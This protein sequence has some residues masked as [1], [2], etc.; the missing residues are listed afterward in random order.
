VVEGAEDDGESIGRKAAGGFVWALLGFLLMQVGGFGTYTVATKIL[1]DSGIGVV[2][3]ALVLVFWIDI[4]LDLG[5]V[6][7]LIYEQERGQTERVQVAFTVNLSVAITVGLLI[8]FGAGLIDDLFKV[9]DER[10]FRVVALLVLVKGFGQVPNAMLERELNFKRK[11][12][13]DIVRSVGR[14]AI[15]ITLLQL[16]VGPIAM[17][18]GVTSAEIAAVSVTWWL[19]R[20]KFILRFDRVIATEMLKF[21]S[22]MFF[23]RLVGM[24]W[25]N[26]DNLI[27]TRYFGAR[28]K[29]F[30]N[31]FTA[32]RLPELI[33]GSVY[34]LFSNVA[35]PAYS[36]A[37]KVG[38]EVLREASLK[39]LRILC[40]FGFVVGTGMALIA[41]DFIT[42]WFD[43]RFLSAIPIMELLCAGAGFAAVGYASGDLYAAMGKPRMGLYFNLIFVP[44]LLGGFVL[45]IHRGVIW[46]A[47]VHIAVIVPYSAFRIEVANRL[48]GTTWRQSLAALRPAAAATAG[49][50]AF[51]L[52]V[53][54]TLD[55]GWLSLFAVIVAGVVGAF[56]GLALGDRVM[57]AELGEGA[58]KVKERVR[59]A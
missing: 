35:F 42:V 44:F 37:R 47:I 27:I 19:T 20:F 15:T 57:L 28:S 56:A 5:L 21:G 46:V 2:A 39:S 6:A 50:V 38:P 34:N 51:G 52:P 49:I 54:L 48:L 11:F 29:E 7:S 26:G 1:G 33:L 53:R 36:A 32:F 25:L 45:F 9:G 30:G 8:F 14:F 13:A 40:L 55:A 24:L 17:V 58:Q 59:P 10:I 31:Y 16:G 4:L 23:A 12:R 18:I 43:A 22:A 41:R 3:S